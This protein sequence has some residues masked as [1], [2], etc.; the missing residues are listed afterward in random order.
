LARLVLNLL[1][2]SVTALVLAAL[3]LPAMHVVDRPAAAPSPPAVAERLFGVYVDPW[4]LDDWTR[5]VGATPQLD[6]KFEAFSNRRTISRFL[7]E[8]ERRGVTR[9]LVSWEPWKPVPTARGIAAQYAP[10][11][12]YRNAD[13]A[14][15]WQDGYLRRF[16]RSLARFQ[17]IVYLRY[18]HEMNGFWYP[19]SRDAPSYRRAWRHVVR[20]VRSGADNVRFVWSVNPSL[21]VAKRSWARNLQSYWPGPRFVDVVGSTMINFGGHK[22]YAVHRFTPRLTTLWRVYRKP[23]M[24]TEANTQY[25]HRVLWLRNLRQML[26]EM[27]WLKAVAWSQLPSRGRAHLKHVGRLDWDV[28]QDPAAAAVLR[29]I[30]RDGQTRSFSRGQR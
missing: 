27:P 2:G 10:Q 21:Y 19:W 24:I 11:L 15:G 22:R 14:R 9:V 26:S 7:R 20:V 29:D 17:G 16:A 6:A 1:T 5:S 8:A 3:L 12:G 18:A 4:H 30:V 13:I 23:V 28:Q 25:Y